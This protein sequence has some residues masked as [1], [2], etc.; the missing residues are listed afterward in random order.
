[1][2]QELDLAADGYANSHGDG[3]FCEVEARLPRAGSSRP[4]GGPRH[5]P[6]GQSDR[7]RRACLTP[8]APTGGARDLLVLVRGTGRS[9]P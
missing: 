2:G 4:G 3:C 1:M 8:R 6:Q 5:Q 7:R 9:R